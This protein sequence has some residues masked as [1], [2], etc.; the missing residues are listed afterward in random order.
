M[1]KAVRE[2]L[3]LSRMVVVGSLGMCA[4][5]VLGQVVLYGPLVWA[6]TF[7]SKMDPMVVWYRL[8]IPNPI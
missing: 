2:F 8:A 1:E 7:F 5:Q 6:L 4:S 3:D